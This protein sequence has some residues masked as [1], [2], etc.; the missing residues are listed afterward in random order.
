MTAG[1]IA[2]NTPAHRITSGRPRRAPSD[3]ASPGV[4]R[5]R[6]DSAL[7]PMISPHQLAT[8]V[9]VRGKRNG[10]GRLE[11]QCEVYCAARIQ[12]ACP[13]SERVVALIVLCGVLK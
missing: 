4:R 11:V 1:G 9:H 13:L 6:E 8:P 12:K 10:Q 2:S 7:Y 5:R 3:I